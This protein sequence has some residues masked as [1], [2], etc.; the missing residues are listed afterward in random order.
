M[1]KTVNFEHQ[2]AHNNYKFPHDHEWDILGEEI[3]PNGEI[4]YFVFRHKENL[5]PDYALYNSDEVE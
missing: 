1:I 5:D 2:N 3:L 4:K